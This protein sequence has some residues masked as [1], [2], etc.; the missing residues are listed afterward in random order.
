MP[1]V[2][3][4]LNTFLTGE[5]T[6]KMAGLVT[7]PHYQ[8]GADTLS[9]FLPLKLGG[10]RTR[11][12][13]RHVA[14]ATNAAC[15]VIPFTDTDGTA[16]VLELTNLECR[17]FNGSYAREVS[18]TTVILP[19][20]WSGSQGLEVHYALINGEMFLVHRSAAPRKITHSGGTW[21]ISTPD[22]TG[23][24]TFSTTNNYPGVVGVFAGRLY[25]GSTNTEP[26]AVFGSKIPTGTT[27]ATNYTDFLQG[28]NPA[29]SI[30]LLESDMNCRRLA[31]LSN[32][33]RL[34]SGTDRSVWMS[35]GNIPT[36]STFDMMITSRVGS[37]EIMPQA[38]GNMLLY[39]GADG[40]T[41]RALIYSYD[42]GGYQDI[43]ISETADHLLKPG[44]I[45]LAV[46]QNPEP[47]AWLLL[48]D[49]TLV[50]ATIRPIQ[51]GVSAAFAPHAL[52]G[53]GDVK[54]LCVAQRTTR[55][56]V[57]FVCDRD[58]NTSI[59]Y[60]YLDDITTTAIADCFYVDNGKTL[61]PASATVSGLTWLDT[62][63]VD[64]VG[65]GAILPRKTVASNAVTYDRT[66]AK[67][68]IGL[69]Y[70]S[71]FKNLR[72]ELQI[73]NTWQGKKKQLIE[74]TV[75]MYNSYGGYAGQ[76]LNNLAEMLFDVSGDYV[77]GESPELFTGDK[78]VQLASVVDTS[79]Q[80]YIERRDPLP[81]AVLAV[82][83]KI[84]IMEA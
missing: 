68:Q 84:E 14:I 81:V 83:L 11:P 42:A 69:P 77:Y 34:L 21:A 29:D 63:E 38:M 10:F 72:P 62:L 31:W 57:W 6:P 20:P 36:P 49:G 74:A 2:T 65:D 52:G 25:F 59:E 13:T 35:D 64:A 37:K 28:T 82:M 76:D 22:F 56:E 61:A 60:L 39:V 26:T 66:I 9:N 73:N 79:G 53:D 55:D 24:R 80:F 23:S 27:G 16:Y 19:T 51:G 75:R 4:L 1:N 58:L 54:S 43:D 70:I 44:I 47:I 46:M 67:I 40:M 48:A 15:R 32:F 18:G 33:G 71:R 50:S 41:L 5:I 45:D 7:S 17:I 30:Y 8:M 78:K 12:G 3:M